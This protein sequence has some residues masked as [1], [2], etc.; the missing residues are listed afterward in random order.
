[1]AGLFANAEY[2]TGDAL[3][4]DDLLGI[5]PVNGWQNTLYLV[6]G[7]IGLAMSAG[8]ARLYCLCAAAVWTLLAAF[9]YFG[10]HGGELIHNMGGVLLAE[11]ANNLVYLLLAVFA[12]AALA[13]P[14]TPT[15][16]KPKRERPPKR[17][18]EDRPARSKREKPAR[19]AKPKRERE[20]PAAEREPER[21]AAE[22]E[23]PAKREAERPAAAEPERETEPE[24]DEQAGSSIG[25]PRSA[26]RGKHP[27]RPIN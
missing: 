14:R 12:L 21:P 2:G 10:A 3:V 17:A 13:A 15:Q 6:A 27:R 22:R 11:P 8:A 20:R 23:R 1:L 19:P 4:A 16:P 26:G 24:R 9:G 7:A 5:L 25:R 18:R